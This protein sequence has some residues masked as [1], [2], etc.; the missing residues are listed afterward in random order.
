MDKILFII[1]FTF[2]GLSSCSVESNSSQN[3]TGNSINNVDNEKKDEDKERIV[4]K[5]GDQWDFCDCVKNNDSIDKLLKNQKLSDSE[6]DEL[7]KKAAEVENKCKVLFTDL[8]SN[9]PT[10]RQRHKDKVKDCLEN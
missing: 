8:K 3:A 1:L 4:K 2:W 6:L 9:K 7:L 5:Y 10:E